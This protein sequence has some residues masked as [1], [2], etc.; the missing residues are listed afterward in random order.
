MSP[1]SPQA[2]PR[3]ANA[4]SHRKTRPYL[5][6]RLPRVVDPSVPCPYVDPI[7]PLWS[8]Y[9]S[10]MLP[11]A[12]LSPM[13]PPSLTLCQPYLAPMLALSSPSVGPILALGCPVSLNLAWLAPILALSGPYGGNMLTLSYPYVGPIWPLCWPYLGLRLPH[14][15]TKVTRSKSKHPQQVIFFRSGAPPEPQ[16]HVKRVVFLVTPR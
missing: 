7:L 8:P 10:P 9:L 16:N 3:T 13:V 14:R 5:G 2:G 4:T 6:L 12:Y 11:L 1:R 15:V